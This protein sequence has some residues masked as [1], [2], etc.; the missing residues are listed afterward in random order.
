MRTAKHVGSLLSG[1]A[2]V[3]V[4]LCGLGCAAFHSL[5]PDEH[6]MFYPCA[7]YRDPDRGGWVVFVRGWVYEDSWFSRN[8]SF[9]GDVLDVDDLVPDPKE[10]KV[11]RERL[12][13]F[14]VDNESHKTLDIYI[15][16]ARYR[17]KPTGESG[18][19]SDRILVTDE[20]VRGQ[21]ALPNGRAGRLAYRVATWP[22]K[23]RVVTGEVFLLENQGLS[24]VSDIDDT[25][26][27]TEV[28]HTKRMLRS[29]FLRPFVPVPGMAEVYAAWAAEHGA[30]FHYLSAAPCQLYEPI[31]AFL[32][33]HG[34]PE[35]SMRLKSI[36]REGGVMGVILGLFEAPRSFKRQ[37]LTDLMRAVPGRRFVLIGDSAQEDPEIYADIARD[38]PELVER[39]LI[40]NVTCEGREAPR[41]QEAF[42][43]LPPESWV[44][45]DEAEEIRDLDLIRDVSR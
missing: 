15:G 36:K 3:A 13:P 8:L 31:A 2:G 1:L 45:F 34:F 37:G 44:I 33:E 25:I 38:F 41:Y 18:H 20:Q 43:D 30:E 27:I 16:E 14:L 42:R 39:I 40:R 4:V 10:R 9:L 21:G 6:A 7:G 17:L 5:S 35:G 23:D 24:I 26:R 19:V 29:T 11:L 22:S 28:N 32:R 12:R